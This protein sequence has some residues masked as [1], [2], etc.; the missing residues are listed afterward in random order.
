[1][2]DT[3]LELENVTKSF[4][5]ITAVDNVSFEVE[6]GEIKGLIGPNGAGKTTLFNLVTGVFPPDNGDIYLRGEKINDLDTED[7]IRKG[8]GRSYQIT[9]NFA[10]LTVRENLR[11]IPYDETEKDQEKRIDELIEL[12]GLGPVETEF[13]TSLSFGQKKLLEMARVLMV[14]ADVVLLDE[15]IAGVNPTLTNKLLEVINE[16]NERGVTFM[17]IEH[18]FGVI[19]EICDNIIALRSG[20]V[21]AR[22]TPQEISENNEL[23]EAYFGGG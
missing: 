21:K 18:N 7:R 4:G 16:L 13:P 17:V 2:V 22:G 1:M 11:V 14:G 10:D 15:P 6:K 23:I 5:A 12:T 3:V 20:S 19:S 9:R 8:I